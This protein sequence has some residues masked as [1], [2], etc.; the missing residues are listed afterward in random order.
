MQSGRQGLARFAERLGAREALPDHG[1]D[2]REQV[3]G[4]VLQLAA[5]QQLS[6]LAALA[7]SDIDEGDD[8]AVDVVLGC[9]VGPDEHH[10]GREHHP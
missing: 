9:A 2:H 4:A 8:D 5:Q 10:E 1:L 6:L 7:F 3:V